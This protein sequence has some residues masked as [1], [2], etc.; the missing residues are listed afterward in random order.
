MTPGVPEINGLLILSPIFIIL[1]FLPA[2]FGYW[3][4]HSKN[5]AI[6]VLNILAGWTM[7]G[8]IIACVWAFTENNRHSKL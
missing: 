3:R 2:I 4:K 8:W 6:M 7:I 1:Y 5:T